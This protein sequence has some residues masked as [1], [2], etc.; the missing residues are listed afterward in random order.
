MPEIRII[1]KSQNASASH[2]KS[3]VVESLRL[4]QV[5]G[6]GEIEIEYL[7]SSQIK[8]INN[9]FRA[10]NKPTDVLSFPQ[11]EFP[12]SKILGTILIC[13]DEAKKRD[14]NTEDLIK[15]GLLHILGYD[16]ESKLSDWKKAAKILSLQV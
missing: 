16:H 11:A 1:G 6:Y 13:E 15:H 7:T 8:K 14:E 4:L 10:I 5:K 12:N 3:I 2:V 9:Q